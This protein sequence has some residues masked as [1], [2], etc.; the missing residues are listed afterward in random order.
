[1]KKVISTLLAVVLLLSLALSASAKTISSDSAD[2]VF[3]YATNTQGKAV[4]LKIIPLDELKA[5]S[6]GQPNGNNY[7]VSTTDNYP[8]TQY[9]EARGVTVDELLSYVKAKSTVSGARSVGFSGEDELRLMATDGYGSYSRNWTYDELYGVKRYY[10]EG[11]FNSWRMGWEIAGEDNSKFGLSLEEYNERYSGKDPYYADKRAVFDGG[12][13]M[14]VILAVESYSGRTTTDTLTA[15]TEPGIASYIAANGG[16]AAGSLKNALTEDYALRLCLPMTEADLMAA[17]R[18][19]YDNFKWIYNLCLDMVNAPELPSQ[20]TVEA[21]V[22]TFGLS[23]NT[24]TVTLTSATSGASIYYGFDGAAQTLYTGPFTVDVTGRDL[25]ASPV[26]VY[27][28]AVKEGWDDEGM[29]TLKYPG[30]AP[31][32]KTLYSGMAGETL[33]FSAADGVSNADWTSWTNAVT[34]VSLKTPSAGGY[35]T[36]DAAKYTIDNTSKSISFD[37]SLFTQSGSYS[38]VFHAAKYA[39]KGTSVTIKQAAPE[40]RTEAQTVF[41][42]RVTVSFDNAAYNSG[43]SVYVTP[44]NGSR[45]MISSNYLD[46][47]KAGQVSINEEYFAMDSGAMKTPGRYTL[48]LVNNSFSPESQSMELTLG[49]ADVAAGSWYYDYV[50]DL[51]GAGTVSGVGGGRF[52]PDGTLTYG[53][54]MKLLMLSTGYGEQAPTSA[55]WAGGYMDTAASD[56]LIAF[57]TDPDAKIS[58]LEF[59]RAAAKALGVETSLSV[60]PFPD[61]SDGAVLALY[62]RGIISGNDDGSFDPSGTLTRAQISRIIWSMLNIRGETE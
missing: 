26:M 36:L 3:F 38:F 8:T 13:E 10:F 52:N 17:H 32:F 43:L 6:H 45:T 18:T 44:A 4:L 16:T 20:G 56:G 23:G 19:A 41:G 47:T 30:M 48:E 40:L 50:M 62:E 46:R 15:S 49:F 58:R 21:P 54:A 39:D 11:L 42:Q 5:L 35:A 1:M 61:T 34:F 57:G 27:A 51:A 29:Q 60:S 31:A 9:C 33:V 7:Y 22:A 25:S 24:L 14:P 28:S 59:C 12:V 2:N 53:E 55:H 37:A